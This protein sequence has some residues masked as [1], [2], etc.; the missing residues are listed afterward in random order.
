[1]KKLIY[2]ILIGLN[3]L[4]PFGPSTAVKPEGVTS[5][6]SVYEYSYTSID[7]KAVSLKDYKGKYLMIVNVAS[8]CGYTPQYEELEKLS[9]AYKEN[10]VIVGFPANDFGQ[11]EP[12]SNEEIAKFCT[13]TYDVTFPMASKI[14]VVGDG[15]HPIYKWLTD[16]SLNGW[17]DAAPKWNFTKYLIGKDG[18]LLRLF[19]SKVKPM[20]EE[21]T[22]MLK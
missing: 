1:M 16:K 18:E 14:S 17:N 12:G 21:I 9:R 6:K 7:G 8:K 19:P 5:R 13:L 2:E 20:S 3:M 4:I 22:G 11:Q 10:L 15:M